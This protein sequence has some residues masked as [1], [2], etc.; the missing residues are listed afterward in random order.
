MNESL[1]EEMWLEKEHNLI[2]NIEWGCQKLDIGPRF[3]AKAQVAC[4][5]L[6]SFRG[7]VWPLR[8]G[9]ETEAGR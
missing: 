7:W 6:W 5:H 1:V 3:E 2:M 8:D 9:I 4:W